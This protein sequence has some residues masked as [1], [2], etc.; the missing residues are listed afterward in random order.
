MAERRTVDAMVEGST[1]F[2]HPKL[3]KHDIRSAFLIFRELCQIDPDSDKIYH[4]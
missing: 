2:S 1:P 3:A 4:W